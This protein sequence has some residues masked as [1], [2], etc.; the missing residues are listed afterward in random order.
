M[1]PGLPQ[2]A[3]QATWLMKDFEVTSEI[4]EK[5]RANGRWTV[6][7]VDTIK[8]DGTDAVMKKERKK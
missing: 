6:S 3:I 7:T 2:Q 4:C 1:R 8:R 5:L